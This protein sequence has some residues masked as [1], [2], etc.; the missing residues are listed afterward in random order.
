MEEPGAIVSLGGLDGL[1]CESVCGSI[2]HLVSL[3]AAVGGCAGAVR[4]LSGGRAGLVAIT[5]I[6]INSASAGRSPSGAGRGG[7][8]CVRVTVGMARFN[9]NEST[10]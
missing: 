3:M 5:G 9:P 2:S 4:G 10:R 7:A 6:A 8:L 1:L